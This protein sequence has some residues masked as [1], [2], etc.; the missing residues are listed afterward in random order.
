MR[1]LA[2]T[3]EDR[4][5]TL[6]EHTAVHGPLPR[7]GEA[8]VDLVAASGLTGRGGAGYPLAG[9][10]RTVI[11]QPRRRGRPVVVV[12]AAE[13]EPA[14]GKDAALTARAPHLV[15]DGATACAR[16]VGARDVVVWVHRGAVAG[17]D[18]LAAAAFE[19]RCA[20]VDA[21]RV[22]V[23][24]GPDRYVAGEASAVVRHLSGGPARPAMTPYRTAER[25]VR[26][27]PTLLANAE[28]FAHVGLVV[29]HGPQWYRSVGTPE[30]PGTALVTVRGGV[31]RPGVVEVPLGTPV[32]DVLDARGG[33]VGPL[34]ALLVGG[35]GASWLSWADARAALVSRASMAAAGADL[36]TGLL[37]A[38]PAERCPVAETERLTG[39]LAAE[40]AGQCGPCVNGLPAIA[41][42]VSALADGD[43]VA[44]DR[45]RRRVGLV[46]GRGACHHPDG[47]AR[48]V[49]SLLV[50]FVDH[51][52]V[53][54]RSGR[55]TDVTSSPLA[56]LP[57][58]APVAGAESWR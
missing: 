1:L 17:P 26:G 21:A 33:P 51:L 57:S 23:V 29:R 10:L 55:C 3:R 31:A 42:D 6:A 13:S 4:P 58:Y 22:Q 39:W 48:L 43:P 27:R 11:D 40:S 8:L 56:P 7:A 54:L 5:L 38:L 44:A 32:T 45:L 30:E 37:L 50:V 9:K 49:R 16:A 35:Y 47:V 53:H 14:A 24:A 19:R 20:G 46:T 2:G 12:N 28:T 18:A 25:G 34:S 15:L 52:D 36:G 41:A